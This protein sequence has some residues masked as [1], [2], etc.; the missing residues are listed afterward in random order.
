MRSG[1][2]TARTPS[3]TVTSSSNAAPF[4][5]TMSGRSG[6]S[7]CSDTS[8]SSSPWGSMFQPIAVYGP[9]CSRNSTSS[10]PGNGFA[11]TSPWMEV[12]PPETEPSRIRT[13]LVL[14]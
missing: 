10:V 14:K 3:S 1:S 6:N 5:V 12:P 11:A 2:W 9:G 8:R 7:S 13:R 4:S